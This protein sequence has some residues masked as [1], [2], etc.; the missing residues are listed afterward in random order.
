MNINI[1][2]YMNKDWSLVGSIIFGEQLFL[3]AFN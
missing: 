2:V 3:T 1:F